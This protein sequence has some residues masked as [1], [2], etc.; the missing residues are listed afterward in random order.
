MLPMS[1]TNMCTA[2]SP[3]GIAAVPDEAREALLE[4]RLA[5]ARSE[6]LSW[7]FIGTT[8]TG[9]ATM[10]FTSTLARSPKSAA[11]IDVAALAR[12]ETAHFSNIVKTA[13]V[14]ASESLTGWLIV[15]SSAL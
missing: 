1:S 8:N 3:D 12:S 11:S 4:A 14:F 15:S 5:A 13:A 7:T 6:T 9:A 10:A 2:R